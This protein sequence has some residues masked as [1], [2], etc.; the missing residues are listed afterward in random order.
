MTIGILPWVSADDAAPKVDVAIVTAMTSVGNAI[1]MLSWDV[2]I[3]RGDAEAGT[4]SEIALA[5]KAQ[6]PVVLL[7][8]DVATGTFLLGDVAPCLRCQQS[9]KVIMRGES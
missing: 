6:H 9:S 2:V 7:N 8:T 5:S 1:T 3:A 4:L